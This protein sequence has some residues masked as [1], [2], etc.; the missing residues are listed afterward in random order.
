[1]KRLIYCLDGTSNEYDDEHPTNVVMMHKSIIPASDDGINQIAYYHEGVGTEKGSKILGIAFGKGLL[2]N[3][4]DAYKHLVEHYK[5][6]DE[7]YIFGFSRGAFTARSFAGLIGWCSIVDLKN[8]SEIKKAEAYYKKRLLKEE[9]HMNN[10]RQWRLDNCS[11]VCANDDDYAF[12]K[13]HFSD[14][15][16]I[17][18]II[19]IRYIGVWDTVKTLGLFNKF[20]WHDDHLSS[21]VNYA[22]HAIAIDERRKKFNITRWGNIAELSQKALESGRENKPYQQV[23]FPGTHGSIGGGGAIRGL[24][25]EAF[26]WIRQGAQDAGLQFIETGDAE[27]FSLK[28]NP[29]AWLYNGTGEANTLMKKV[30]RWF[31]KAVYWVTGMIDRKGVKSLDQLHHTATIR[32]FAKP[33]YLPEKKWYRPATLNQVMNA[34]ENIPAPYTEAE[35]QKLF[36]SF[37]NVSSNDG[38]QEIVTISNSKF[39]VYTVIK[40]DTLF[41]IAKK[42]TGEGKNYLKIHEINKASIPNVDL[43][44]IRQRIFIP[45]EL[46]KKKGNV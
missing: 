46:I 1:M 13:K 6:G 17:P 35:Y 12:R 26:Q 39:L 44:Y 38:E 24:S 41:L 11:F 32:Y 40:G 28:P 16:Q 15:K 36:K 25:D 22:R 45:I 34:L 30:T 3:I 20:E 31:F 27:I 42:L 14:D 9:S 5:V 43:I 33:E 10:F 37:T 18:E 2:E 4:M 19:N 29:L 7:I 21:R 8:I 23:W